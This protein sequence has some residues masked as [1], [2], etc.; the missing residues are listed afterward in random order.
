MSTPERRRGTFYVRA[1]NVPYGHCHCGCGGE[2]R[3]STVTKTAKGHV[4]GE[5]QKFLMG[6]GG[7]RGKPFKTPEELF[8]PRVDKRGDGEC[9]NWTGTLQ[10]GG[11]G[12]FGSA[13]KTYLAHRFSYTLAKGEIPEGMVVRHTCDNPK[14]VNPS[15][16][17]VGTHQ[18]NSNDAVER[19]RTARGERSGVAKLTEADVVEIRA[20]YADG[21]SMSGIARDLGASRDSVR[22]VAEGRTWRHVA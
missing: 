5:P 4:K 16:L 21:Q 9:W 7:R 20:R 19:G 14:C 3:I 12:H 10:G 15:H 11:Y 1:D 17:L 2:T 13:G 8:W 22:A 18:D 6:H